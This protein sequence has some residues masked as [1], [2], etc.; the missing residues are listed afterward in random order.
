VL[1][2]GKVGRGK[3]IFAVGRSPYPIIPV[4]DLAKAIGENFPE[5]LAGLLREAV[6]SQGAGE[7]ILDAIHENLSWNFYATKPKSVQV[8]A[9]EP[10]YALAF[11]FQVV[12]RARRGVR[13]AAQSCSGCLGK[14]DSASGNATKA[15]ANV[16]DR[17]PRTRVQPVDRLT[18]DLDVAMARPRFGL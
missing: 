9:D 2:E 1:V 12:R 3:V 17:C 5:A 4:S 15:R 7:D 8:Q 10:I 6:S 14:N 11:K 18:F 16:S 13:N